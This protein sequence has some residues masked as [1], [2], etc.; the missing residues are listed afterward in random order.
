MIRFDQ[1]AQRTQVPDR[2]RVWTLQLPVGAAWAF[3]S[4][5]NMVPDLSRYGYG[6]AYVA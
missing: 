1:A 6:A 5:V 4:F 2:Y 3:G